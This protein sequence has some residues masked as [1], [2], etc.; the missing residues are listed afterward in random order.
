M[1]P[2]LVKPKVSPKRAQEI[3][4]TFDLPMEDI[5]KLIK[6]HEGFEGV[7]YDDGSGN[8]T[9]GYG[10]LIGDGSLAALN[11]SPYKGKTLTEEQALEIAVGDIKRKAELAASDAQLG[12]VFSEMS[13]KL[14]SYV[15]SSYYRGDLSGSP[16]TK[17]LIRERK[18]AEAAD[19][20]L[21]NDEYLA[22][23]R[24]RSGVAPRME[25]TA[26]ALREEVEYRKQVE[27]KKK[28]EANKK[29]EAKKVEGAKKAEVGG[30]V[31]FLSAVEK[32][33]SR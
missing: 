27:A 22:A 11:A 12:E 21:K 8:W 16:K 23:K 13:P 15:V 26:A 31:D 5:K 25:E 29:P 17:K 32:R 24:D 30:N 10:T 33:L 3:A 4:R 28:A 18:F 9:I 14:K 6:R 7:P 2:I 20:F 19:E 1:E